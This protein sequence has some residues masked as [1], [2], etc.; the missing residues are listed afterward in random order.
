MEG[1]VGVLHFNLLFKDINDKLESFGG[2]ERFH[3]RFELTEF[4]HF[5]VKDV[6]DQTDQQVY[7]RNYYQDN[8]PLSLVKCRLKHTLKQHQD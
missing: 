7:L 4:D 8:V 3:V 2:A 1:Y 6:V 5:Q